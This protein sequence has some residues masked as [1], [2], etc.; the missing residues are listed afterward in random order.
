[1]FRAAAEQ[2]DRAAQYCIGRMY[3][4]GKGVE[5]DII[6]AGAY[7]HQAA[8]QGHA[9]AQFSLARIYEAGELSLSGPQT[10]EG[11]TPAQECIL[12]L[13]SRAAETGHIKANA[14]LSLDLNLDTRCCN[15]GR[16]AITWDSCTSMAI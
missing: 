2:G 3:K 16:L 10:E 4:F 9:E 8:Q 7:L 15:L 13:Y 12:W 14:L 1:M 11:K 5:E 6:L